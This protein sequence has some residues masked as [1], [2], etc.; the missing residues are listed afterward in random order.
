VEPILLFD[1]DGVIINAKRF[2]QHLADDF[3]ITLDMTKEFFMTIFPECIEGRADLQKTIQPYLKQW[4]WGKSVEEFLS[5]WFTSEH[6]VDS[7]LIALIQQLRAVGIACYVATNQ[8]NH[9]TQYMREKMQF[10]VWF[11]GG[12]FSA[13]LGVK[14]PKQEFYAKVAKQ[15]QIT[16]L[17]CVWFIDDTPENVAAAEKFGFNTVLYEDLSEFE[18][19]VVQNR[20]VDKVIH[21]K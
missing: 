5:Y 4:G 15:L 10:G 12:F 17:Q 8:E 3:G 18:K 16:D 1:A 20:W 7:K 11:D 14:K 19:L 13:E 9:R 6:F 2:S 21:L